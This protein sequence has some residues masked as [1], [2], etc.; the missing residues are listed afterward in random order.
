MGSLS[1]ALGMLAIADMATVHAMSKG[2]AASTL[3]ACTLLLGCALYR[4][5]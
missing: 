4:G 1:I 3:G 2:E 5:D